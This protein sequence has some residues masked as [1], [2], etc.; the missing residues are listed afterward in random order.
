MNMEVEVP[1]IEISNRT[2]EVNK[3][4]LIIERLFAKCQEQ[5]NTIELLKE[6]IN[7]LKG[8]KNKPNIKPSKMD[9][10][11]KGNNKGRH[12]PGRMKAL[13]RSLTNSPLLKF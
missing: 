9:G 2:P 3:L 10:D 8:H 12:N 5:E 6:E 1:Q 11:K 7:R 4:Y 13:L